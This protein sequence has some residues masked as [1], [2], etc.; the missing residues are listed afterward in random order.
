LDTNHLEVK[1]NK[2]GKAKKWQSFLSRIDGW[3]VVFI[4]LFLF[5][6]VLEPA[7]EAVWYMEL[8]ERNFLEPDVV[9]NKSVESRSSAGI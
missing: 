6:E 5:G 4:S 9:A 2:S 1:K 8:L 7:A 3:V